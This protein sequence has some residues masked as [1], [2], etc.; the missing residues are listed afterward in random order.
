MVTKE[1]ALGL[2]EGTFDG[3][4][5]LS[6]AELRERFAAALASLEDES[7]RTLP[8]RGRAVRGDAAPA[9]GEKRGR[10]GVERPAARA[11]RPRSRSMSVSDGEREA[12]FTA[13]PI[14]D[15][16]Y[17]K[18]RRTIQDTIEREKGQTKKSVDQ[19]ALQA[20]QDH[21]KEE[22]LRTEK[23]HIK[24]CLRF[25]VGI[26]CDWCLRVPCSRP[27]V[28]GQT[29]DD[30]RIDFAYLRA[31]KLPPSKRLDFM[32]KAILD[33]PDGPGRYL[34][35][36]IYGCRKPLD[37]TQYSALRRL[38]VV[39]SIRTPQEFVREALVLRPY[40]FAARWS[41]GRKPVEMPR[42]T[43]A[44]R[45]RLVTKVVDAATGLRTVREQAAALPPLS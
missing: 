23:L 40:Q 44:A 32:N 16:V 19:Y 11:P 17:D 21:K 33:D 28:F 42:Y 8:A 41:G 27:E 29:C 30:E 20:T 14:Q 9:V 13:P 43:G 22:L 15:E 24:G 34:L 36:K 10:G 4:S 26:A 38:W 31:R 7:P 45:V 6:V 18:Y 12:P 2:L 39:A 25:G 1:Q 35:E 37:D 3:A 5:A